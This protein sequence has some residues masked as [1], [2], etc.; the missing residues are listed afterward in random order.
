[1]YSPN[2]DLC[3]SGCL[4]VK[5]D[6]VFPGEFRNLQ[7]ILENEVCVRAIFCAA[8]ACFCSMKPH[9]TN[10]ETN[11]ESVLAYFLDASDFRQ[12]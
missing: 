2:L 5:K 9:E 1:M 7:V 6:V 11:H 4:S 10:H 8:R 12:E 3:L